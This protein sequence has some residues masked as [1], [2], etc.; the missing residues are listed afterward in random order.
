MF[1]DYH[2]HTKFSDDS[3]YPM[4]S[5]V[6]DAISMGMEEI[7]FTDHVDYGIKRDWDCGEEIPYRNG[8][9]F[10]N[11]DY[12]RYFQEIERLRDLY[13]SNIRIKVGMEFGIQTHTIPQYERL[14][15]RY[16]FDYILLSI[17]QVEDKEFWT[18]DFQQGR[19]Q[20]E[21]NERYYKEMLGVIKEYKNYSVLAHLDLITR[22]DKA[23]VY[24]FE[25]VKPLITEILRTAIDDEKGI[26]FNTS[27]HRYGLE[28]TTPSVEILKLYRELGGTIL[29]IGSD[30]HAPKHLGSYY[31][32]AKSLLKQLGFRSICTYE[33]MKPIFHEL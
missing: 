4:E 33:K 26:E 2:V 12:P 8:E 21:Y 31:S 5:V 17:H 14:F 30:S 32:E 1:A 13:G 15:S 25:Q 20:Q 29:T 3:V 22:Y 11:V 18:Q 16:A 24:P 6:R 9:P 28:D 7:C 19:S 27:Y 23:G 10:A